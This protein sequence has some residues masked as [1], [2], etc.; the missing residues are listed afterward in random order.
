VGAPPDLSF[1]P[2]QPGIYLYKDAKGKILYVGKARSI[3]KRLASY[4]N[5]G[6]KHPKT[7]A[8]LAEFATI[9]TVVATTESEALALEN[10][11]IK[12]HKPRYNILLRDDK[13]YPYIKVTTGEAWPRAFVTRRVLRDGHS[14]FGPFLPA[15]TCRGAMKMVQRMFQIRTCRIEIDGTL[16]R[17]CLYYDMHACLGPCVAG[18]TTKAAYDEA[19]MDVLLFLS[20]RNE[21]LRP[22]LEEKMRAAAESE[23]FEMAA[24]YR[25]C[26]RT[27]E[28]LAEKQ[29]V[30]SLS[31]EDVDVFGDFS[32]AGNLA[33][34]ILFVRGGVV[35][36][37]REY[38]WERL[39]DVPAEEFW[40]SLL[41][42][43]YDGTTFLPRDIL[44]PVDL[45]DDALEPIE[46]W[47]TER[48]GSRVA[49]KTPRRGAAFER[50]QIARDNAR[51][52]HLRRFRR[53]H[54]R[55][56]KAT[57]ALAKA[58]DLD[59]RPSR[60]ECFDISH[61]QGSETYAS[62]VVFVD[63]EPAKE[64]YRLFRIER[65]GI[66]DFASIAEA[67]SRR[68]A[69]AK[70]R[71][72]P[73]PDLL[74]IDGGK[75][76]LSAA[77]SALDRIG[78]QMAAASLAKREEQVFVPGRSAPIVLARTNAGLKLLQRARDEAHR[79]GLKS[80]RRA[81]GKRALESPLLAIPGLG[82][83]RVRTLLAAFGGAEAVLA[84]TDG[85][86]TAVAGKAVA[87]RVVRFRENRPG[88]RSDA[89]ATL[90]EE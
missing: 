15:R 22:R 28:E 49:I 80:H 42:Q 1:Y 41:S 70:E 79:F 65:P 6:P 25:D 30:Q 50:V 16:P 9:D 37:S 58:L 77:L 24:A 23:A 5:A 8:L 72:R 12:K 81:R 88:E 46:A 67:V 18:L 59:H 4:F 20:G 32:D 10:A 56:E 35:L 83:S 54:E 3:R 74:L 19:V 33:V 43:F 17:P 71:G 27:V 52:N 87:A 76:Q 39:G 60:I 13:T 36:D 66:D 57:L 7:D 34:S 2:D 45:P 64:E 90:S 73:L 21:E 86:L 40:I 51:Q 75:G 62:C 78:V 11:F 53:V 48:R 38:F 61:L 26:L 85:A 69:S 63:G 82:P 29:R 44:L 55:G 14:Y 31:G 68:Y 89:A 84:A 47:L